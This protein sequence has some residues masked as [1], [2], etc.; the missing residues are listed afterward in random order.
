MGNC[1][2]E[3]IGKGMKFSKKK[4][5]KNAAAGIKRQLKGHADIL[6]GMEVV[7]GG[8]D[9]LV[10][11]YFVDGQEDYLYPVDKSWCV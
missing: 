6:D 7:F 10:P 5:Q 9:G 2:R 3:G 11:L 1:S 4:F 8:E